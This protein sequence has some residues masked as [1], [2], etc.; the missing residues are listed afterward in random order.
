MSPLNNSDTT[1]I[2]PY[3]VNRIL[4]LT[5]DPIKLGIILEIIRN[6]DITTNELK[7]R[8]NIPG[9]RI[10]YFLNQL[11]DNGI[12]EESGTEKLTKTLS[13]R[14]FRISNWFERG[15][16]SLRY[17]EEEGHSKVVHL[18][19]LH[20]AIAILNQQ[21]RT[22]EKIPDSEF[23]NYFRKLKLPDLEF[24]FLDEKTL[25]ILKS[26]HKEIK[27]QMSSMQENGK[28]TL[29]FL[30]KSSHVSLF[31]IYPME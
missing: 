17:E 15:I 14:K 22:L 24:Y 28:K 21:V 1:S 4:S 9:S 10:Y 26:K 23:D 6:P 11:V 13:R 27:A 7:K 16:N 8:L 20:F 3:D 29:D 31:G 18:F 5:S 30:K 12:I 2:S 25:P 19:Q